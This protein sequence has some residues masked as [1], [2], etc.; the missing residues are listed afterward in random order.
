MST[1]RGRITV[2][3]HDAMADELTSRTVKVGVGFDEHSARCVARSRATPFA[4]GHASGQPTR[5]NRPGKLTA[6][7]TRQTR[8][9]K[10]GPANPARQTRPGKPGPANPARQTDR[11]SDPATDPSDPAG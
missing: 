4:N 6:Q 10:P 8:P 11:A 1:P 2:R 5:Q 3:G 9:G 7:A